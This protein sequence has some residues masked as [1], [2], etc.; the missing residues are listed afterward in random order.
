[1]IG[2]HASSVVLALLIMA[3]PA[4]AQAVI[5]DGV[6]F[7]EA[8]KVILSVLPDSLDGVHL[9]AEPRGEEECAGDFWRAV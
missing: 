4:E 6:T 7:L 5:R 1:M 9:R 8:G 3:P 2:R